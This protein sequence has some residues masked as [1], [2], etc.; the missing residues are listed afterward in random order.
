MIRGDVP[1]DS[2][3]QGSGVAGKDT[4]YPGLT[5]YVPLQARALGRFGVLVRHARPPDPGD[6]RLSVLLFPTCLAR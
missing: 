4:M 5:E 3:L 2:S 1:G 6:V